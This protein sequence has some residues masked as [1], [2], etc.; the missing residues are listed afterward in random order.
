VNDFGFT[1]PQLT[2]AIPLKSAGQ[3]TI[4]RS[5]ELVAAGRKH[6]CVRNRTEAIECFGANDRGQLGGTPAGG[7]TE[8][9]TVPLP[10]A[11]PAAIATAIAAGADHTCAIVSGGRL[12]CWG[13]NDAGQLGN[14]L[15]TDPGTGSIV[16]PL[17]R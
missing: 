12:R 6:V 8:A 15:T 17:G 1:S 13:A 5:A 3:A 16:T 14:G 9:M 4:D 11:P 7:P 2:P 10:A